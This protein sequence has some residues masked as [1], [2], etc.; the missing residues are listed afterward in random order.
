MEVLQVLANNLGRLR[1]ERGL[2]LSGLSQR[3]GIAK[4]TLSNLE[5]GRGNPTVETIWAIANALEV[6]FGSLLGSEALG[7]VGIGDAQ[8][9]VLFMGRTFSEDGASIETYRMALEQGYIK[10][11]AAHPSGV[12]EKIVVTSGPMLVGDSRYPQ[13][14]NSGEIHIFDADVPHIYAAMDKPVQ[15]MVF[16]EYPAARH[17]AAD[18]VRTLNWPVDAEGWEGVHDLVER[19]HTEVANGFRAMMLRLEGCILPPEQALAT[20]REHLSRICSTDYKWPTFQIVDIDRGAPYVAVMPLLFTQ[21]FNS[22]TNLQPENAVWTQA[23]R[24]ARRAEARLMPSDAEAEHSE[25][26]S[27]VLESLAC[28]CALQAGHVRL[29]RQLQHLAQ[30]SYSGITAASLPESFSSRI[31]VD[32]YDAFELLHPAYA[33]Q[34]VAMVEDIAEF[35]AAA[36]KA[37]AQ[38]I[39]VGTGPG[40][41]LL[42]LRELLPQLQVLAVEPDP[43]AF[44]CLQMNTEGLDRVELYQG[45]FLVMDFPQKSLKVI[46]SVG[47]SHHFN[48]AFMLQKAWM[49]LEP[50]GILSVADEFLPPFNDSE[51]RNIALVL[52]HSS[53][54][55]TAAAALDMCQGDIVEDAEFEMF[56]EFRHCLVQAVMKAEQGLAREAVSLCR[57]LYLSTR[58]SQLT[59]KPDHAIGAYTRFFCLELQ[60][61]VA[62]FDYEVERKTHVQRFL[63]LASATGFELLRQR[64]VFATTG[65]GQ[66]D[67]GTHVITMRRPT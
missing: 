5:L 9:S 51:S 42:M 36:M 18:V 54:I 39:D 44:A 21:I 13:R 16:V 57:D 30:R 27:W 56:R 23:F 12:K 49:L 35:N 48:T 50:G 32:H 14:V 40:V 38:I 26:D 3:C 31:Q 2:T 41:P 45:D 47:A 28:E 46:T 58:K 15:A 61:M 55:L 11:S 62:G 53:Y 24:M 52:H 34:V 37:S 43:V 19:I 22:G 25:S 6:P 1:G 67:G 29:P 17:S 63:E 66:R 65:N 20:L 7:H 4:S 64:R 10:H 59:K 33:R 60:A 8:A